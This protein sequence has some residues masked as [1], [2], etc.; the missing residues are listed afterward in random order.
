MLT[1]FSPLT[2]SYSTCGEIKWRMQRLMPTFFCTL[3]KF[4]PSQDAYPLTLDEYLQSLDIDSIIY[5]TYKFRILT[6]ISVHVLPY[7]GARP[8]VWKNSRTYAELL[9]PQSET[10]KDSGG[11]TEWFSNRK[12]LS[13]IPQIHFAKVGHGSGSF[14]ISVMVPRMMHKNPI[15]GK[16]ATL[17]PFEIQ[18]LWFTDMLYPAILA[19]ENPSTMSYKDYTLAE[20]R[21]KGSV[22]NRFTGKDKLIVVQGNYLEK[23]QKVMWDIVASDPDEYDRWLVVLCHGVLR[24]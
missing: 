13:A 12:S 18:S 5:T 21:W 3:I 19:G 2:T 1:G 20:W 7:T 11:R 8:P 14:N 15:T 6:M 10:D 4:D 16:S 17:V 24:H 9:M 22:K 23:M